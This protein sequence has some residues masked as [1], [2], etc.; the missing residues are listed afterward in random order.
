MAKKNEDNDSV[1]ISKEVEAKSKQLKSN[2]EALK[3][4]L[5]SLE[6]KT[7][8]SIARTVRNIFGDNVTIT[9]TK[10]SSIIETEDG[11]RIVLIDKDLI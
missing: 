11:D 9:L 7:A 10:T 6:S 4:A 8:T 5:K 3:K 2:T 1:D